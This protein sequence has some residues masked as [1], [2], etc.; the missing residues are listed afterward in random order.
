[1]SEGK[2]YL[3]QGD[4]Q[5]A[6]E[7][8]SIALNEKKNDPEAKG[9]YDEALKQLEKMRLDAFIN[10]RQTELSQIYDL[11]IDFFF[12]TLS[13]NRVVETQE[14][15]GKIKKIVDNV[16][17]I[18]VPNDPEVKAYNDSFIKWSDNFYKKLANYASAVNRGSNIVQA[19]NE[20]KPFES[21]ADVLNKQLNEFRIKFYHSEPAS[22]K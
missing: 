1:L 17:Q 3:E 18:E 11:K 2:K 6:A 9:L 10:K 5:S 15:L 20:L 14:M 22:G 4:Y 7:L 19:S 12:K 16:S 21:E 13:P 8:F